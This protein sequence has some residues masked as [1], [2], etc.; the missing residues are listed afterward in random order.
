MGGDGKASEGRESEGGRAGREE[1]GN[2]KEVGAV[3]VDGNF[4]FEETRVCR[5]FFVHA[6]ICMVCL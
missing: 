3:T 1:V 5:R 4:L 6:T 2:Q